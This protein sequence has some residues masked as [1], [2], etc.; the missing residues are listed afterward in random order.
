M[1]EGYKLQLEKH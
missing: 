1:K